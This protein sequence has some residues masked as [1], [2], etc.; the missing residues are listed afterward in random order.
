MRVN[1]PD[2]SHTS[3]A[4]A[5]CTWGKALQQA[6]HSFACITLT[7]K[8]ISH[9]WNGLNLFQLFQM[10]KMCLTY[11]YVLLEISA[12]ERIKLI[13]EGIAVVNF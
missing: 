1:F 6:S 10:E 2:T 4:A 11:E 12:N 8:N 9:G 7:V 13:S 3:G 5:C